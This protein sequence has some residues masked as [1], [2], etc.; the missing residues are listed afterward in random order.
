M[1]WALQKCS[2]ILTSFFSPDGASAGANNSLNLDDVVE[3]IPVNRSDP[4]VETIDEAELDLV[5]DGPPPAKKRT[6]MV[7]D[8]T[9][10]SDEEDNA[11]LSSIKERML[12]RQRSSS[13]SSRPSTADSIGNASPNSNSQNNFYKFF[14]F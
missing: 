13:Q 7:V 9:L 12:D 8:L 2:S 3:E 11:T 14:V 6:P 10:S 1:L 4:K 5:C